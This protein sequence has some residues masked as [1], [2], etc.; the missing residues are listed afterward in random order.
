LLS[1]ELATVTSAIADR[2]SEV[3]ALRARIDD[4]YAKASAVVSE[5]QLSLAA[6]LSR[7]GVLEDLPER[8]EER[9]DLL[10]E[11][12]MRLGLVEQR[13]EAPAEE[14]EK[15][16]DTWASDRS[17]L[18]TRLDVIAAALTGTGSG[19]GIAGGWDAEVIRLRVLVDGLQMRLSASEEEI[20]ALRSAPDLASRFD[21]ITNRLVAI[22]RSTHGVFA[23]SNG[24]AAGD[25]RFRLELRALEL[26]LEQEAA[27]AHDGR[28]A[29]LVQLERMASRIEWR[30]QRLESKDADPPY[31][32]PTP[33]GAKV[34]PFR[35][36]EV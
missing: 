14:I 13:G 17:S 7:V 5:L 36:A 8:L 19:R 27:T 3:P 32:A 21:E 29:F 25:G 26:R 1:G 15:I 18:E 31:D 24:P 6:L 10:E 28:D 12:G 34:V 23:S 11:L 2:E 35:S 9:F 4:A 33:T 16:L 22:E 30:L 20:A